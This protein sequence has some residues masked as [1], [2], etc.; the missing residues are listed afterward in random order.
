M[1]DN[2]TRNQIPLDISLQLLQMVG[3][4]W[5]SS[6]AGPL[7]LTLKADGGEERGRDPATPGSRT[8]HSGPRKSAA[9]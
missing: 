2:S 7:L 3:V 8:V 9:S 4:R 6:P 1:A 5:R